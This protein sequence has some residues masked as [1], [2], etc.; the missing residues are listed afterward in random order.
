[1]QDS[2]AT[3]TTRAIAF[4][5]DQEKPI[6]PIDGHCGTMG[7][8]CFVAPSAET[9]TAA[10]MISDTQRVANH[11]NTHTLAYSTMAGNKTNFYGSE[12]IRVRW[13][14][15][16]APFSNFT[17]RSQFDLYYQYT[18]FYLVRPRGRSFSPGTWRHVRPMLPT[19]VFRRMRLPCGSR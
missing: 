3:C 2:G 12:P 7:Q 5:L 14:A 19:L 8:V 13:P 15:S 17:K 10:T 6:N 11:R 4:S 9:M 1:M 18:T 16:A